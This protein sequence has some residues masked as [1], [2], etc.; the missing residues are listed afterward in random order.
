MKRQLAIVGLAAGFIACCV[1]VFVPDFPHVGR[2]IALT[3]LMFALGV[4]IYWL[5]R[6]LAPRRDRWLLIAALLGAA[7]ASRGILLVGPGETFLHSDDVYRYIWDGKV[8][9]SGINPYLYSPD[10]PAL[11][12]LRDAV[13][14][15]GINH[16]H[17][18]TVYPPLAQ[19]MFL[20]VYLVGGDRTLPFKLVSALFELATIVLLLLWLRAARL[21]LQRM[22]LYLFSP[23]VLVEFFL[24]AHVDMLAMPFLVAAL[25]ALERDRPALAGAAL[26]LAAQ[27]KLLGLLFA[28]PLFF[29]LGGTR[30]WRFLLAFCAVFGALYV[31]HGVDG[32]WAVLGSLPT[33]LRRW[34]FFAS[35][36]AL[37]RLLLDEHVA[38]LVVAAAL[39][40]WTLGVSLAPGERHVHERMF[41]VFGAYVALAPAVFPWYLVW[42]FPLLLSNRSRPFLFLTAAILVS[43]NIFAYRMPGGLP[44]PRWALQLACYVPFYALLLGPRL[45]RRVRRLRGRA[46]PGGA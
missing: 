46:A 33:Y 14:H 35:I 7:A 32:G 29:Q 31:P 19:Y 11:A 21:P 28:P 25:L 17:M 42:L 1:L 20:L 27:V 5:G 45:R 40:S 36:F 16:P 2:F 9:A 4:G 44:L 43:Y 37:L 15:P 41:M 38:R 8:S 39:G 10:D 24:S 18:P 23:L 3:Q 34:T 13:I 26:A 30:R 6:E 12:H 22:L